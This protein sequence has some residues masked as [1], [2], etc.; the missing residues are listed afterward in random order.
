MNPTPSPETGPVS[1]KAVSPKRSALLIGSLPFSDE[2]SC[3]RR[4]LD[5]LGPALFCL[6]DGEI[7][8]KSPAFPK[9]NR[10]AWVVYAI[11]KITED[12]A[13][14]QIVRQPVRGED[15]MAV[16]YDGFQKLKPLRSPAELPQHVTL[17]Y[18]TFF[19]QSYP[20]FRRLRAEKNLPN[21]AFQMGVPTGF[22]MGFAF[23]SQLQW[24]RYTYAF[25]TII[26]RE[27]NAALATAGKD[28]IVQIEVPPE[29]YA[30]YKLPTPLMGLALR[31]IKDLLSKI[32]PGAR[33]GM[34]LCLGDFH[35]HALV[36]PKTL[37]KMVAFSNRLVEEWPDR[38]TLEYIHYPF[39]EAGVPPSLDTGYYAPLK[40][41]R[42]PD[43]VRFVA[44]FVHE[45][46]SPEENRR[47]LNS[48]EN[49]RGR[50]VDIA[51][52]CGLG[53]RPPETAE[54]L[55]QLTAELTTV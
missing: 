19:Q 25:N 45:K 37:G 36:H 55:L 46:R 38:H 11:E 6:P 32:T 44:G 27:V 10:I 34:H 9:G 14:W 15:G 16:D 3:M 39:A 51:S 52:S 43:G 49:A 26:A 28:M 21:L 47:I 23:A 33:I 31:P 8:E 5:A 53:R 7:G 2:E 40:D 41:I 20:V 13:N 50:S 54:R 22:A 17:G 29:L 4:A 30:A 18:D 42:L 35:N 24:I 48:I 1:E 12:P